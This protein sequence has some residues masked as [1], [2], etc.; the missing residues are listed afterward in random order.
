MTQ[1]ETEA[2]I[3]TII[4]A[5]EHQY[6]QIIELTDAMQHIASAL[7]EIEKRTDILN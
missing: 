5:I 3:N 7:I 6:R 4:E 2:K 1:A